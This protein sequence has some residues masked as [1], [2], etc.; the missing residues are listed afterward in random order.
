M[1]CSDHTIYA[2]GIGPDFLLPIVLSG[3]STINA[4]PGEHPP[5]V[6]ARLPERT[7]VL[8]F[9][10]NA[11]EVDR[12]LP[13]VREIAHAASVIGLVTVNAQVHDVRKRTI[14]AFDVRTVPDDTWVIVK[15]DYNHG[16]WAETLYAHTTINTLLP[17]TFG[18]NGYQVL[19]KGDVPDHWF[20]D[21]ALAIQP[22][23]ANAEGVFA[24]VYV[25]ADSCIVSRGWETRAIKRMVPGIRR[26]TDVL[27]PLSHRIGP[28]ARMAAEEF[29]A[30]FSLQFGTIDVMHSER[31]AAH[32]VDVNPT[33]YWGPESAVGIVDPL[34]RAIVRAGLK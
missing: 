6:I 16:G 21:P 4:I 17:Q 15:S 22:Y 26:R 9:Q 8:W 14:T 25:A 30:R 29:A 19:R 31:G 34:R 23:W 5:D 27:C 13:N 18:P 24:R 12:A 28:A 20:D 33:P 3:A 1:N 7:R 32:V 11:T 10:I 2:A